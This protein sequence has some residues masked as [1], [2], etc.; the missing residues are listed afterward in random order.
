MA[1]M[2]SLLEESQSYPDWYIE[3]QIQ[4][5]DTQGDDSNE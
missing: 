2:A 5:S 1:K 3:Q 4:A